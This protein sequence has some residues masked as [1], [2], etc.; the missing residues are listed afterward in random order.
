MGEI[1]TDN[2]ASLISHTAQAV[3]S[4]WDFTVVTRSP[5][6]PQANGWW[7]QGWRSQRTKKIL[8][9][10]DPRA[11]LLAHWT[12]HL[13]MG[14]S[15]AQL[16]FNCRLR[17]VVPIMSHLLTPEPLE[18]EKWGQPMTILKGSKN[19]RLIALIKCATSAPW[20]PVKKCSSKTERNG[21]QFSPSGRNE[22][23]TM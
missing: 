9:T 11:A 8:N 23:P 1:F 19:N 4:Q 17:G 6:F 7:K 12:P 18:P 22:D 13:E 21:E 3:A 5:E 20:I 10:P 2:Q 15:P 16:L 14:F